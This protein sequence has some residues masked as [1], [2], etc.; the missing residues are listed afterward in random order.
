MVA[1]SDHWLDNMSF[2]GFLP[3]STSLPNSLICVS[4]LATGFDSSEI[5]T[6]TVPVRL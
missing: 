5:Q 3:F 4:I 2:I 1:K 6:K